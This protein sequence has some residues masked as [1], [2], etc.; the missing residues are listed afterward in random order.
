[1]IAEALAG[2][3]EAD[4]RRHP[5][6]TE[7]AQLAA[8]QISQVHRM[9]LESD[10]VEAEAFRDQV[11]A[12]AGDAIGRFA[13]SVRPAR[14]RRYDDGPGPPG[15]RVVPKLGIAGLSTTPP[16][17]APMPPAKFGGQPDWIGEPQWPVADD[18][19]PLTFH[20]QL[21]VPGHQGQM[22]YVFFAEAADD[23]SW[24]P[25]SSGN[26]VVVQPAG[27]C[28]LP[29]APLRHGPGIWR[30]VEEPG[31]YSRLWGIHERYERYA[32][33]K[34]GLDPLV[35]DYPPYDLDAPRL[36]Y[37]PEM[38][39]D[40]T[41]TNK[42]G[43]TPSWLQGDDVPDGDGWRFAFQWTADWASEELADGAEIYGFIRDSDLAACVLWQ[44]H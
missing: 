18:G 43:G 1:V 35:V 14:L 31:H 33:L 25:L 28:H 30:I 37:E 42:I 12:R 5:R 15:Q 3:P 29:T 32:V 8:S 21:P 24:G 20:A 39:V 40:T 41:D 16:A 11:A 36:P 23:D 34:E 44:C 19:K 26:A 6:L 2:V 13:H 9:L 22:A 7:S 38:P 10:P 17:A 27:T 4:F